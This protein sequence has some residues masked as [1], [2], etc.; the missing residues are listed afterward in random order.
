[1]RHDERV[2]EPLAQLNRD[3]AARPVPSGDQRIRLLLQ[4]LA[5][6]VVAEVAARLCDSEH[7]AD[8]AGD[9]TDRG[10]ARREC[11][12]R[13]DERLEQLV[14]A[15]SLLVGELDERLDGASRHPAAPVRSILSE[16]GNSLF[17]KCSH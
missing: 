8:G 10:P 17:E 5:H 3:R 11:P 1:M 2:G 15:R 14:A 6:L 12:A 7:A 13:V 4:H 9:R 16:L